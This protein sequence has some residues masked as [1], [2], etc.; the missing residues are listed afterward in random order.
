MRI[1][2]GLPFVSFQVDV[3]RHILRVD[4]RVQIETF[5]SMDAPTEAVN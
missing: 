4:T 3:E 1:M 5:A 2:L